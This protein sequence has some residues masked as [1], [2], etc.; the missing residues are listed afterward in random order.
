MPTYNN[1]NPIGNAQ[2]QAWL[3]NQNKPPVP[4]INRPAGSGGGN[5]PPVPT[6]SANVPNDQA[7]QWLQAQAAARAAAQA[8]AAANSRIAGNALWSGSVFNPGNVFGN[9][10]PRLPNANVPWLSQNPFDP[11]QNAANYQS[12][13]LMPPNALQNFYKNPAND[14]NYGAPQRPTYGR[15]VGMNIANALS[16]AGSSALFG[17]KQQ[18]QN[19]INNY[20][21]QYLK[22]NQ[23]NYAPDKLRGIFSPITPRNMLGAA[24]MVAQTDATFL[25]SGIQSRPP[26]PKKGGGPAYPRA[27][28]Q[29]NKKKPA[30]IYGGS[31]GYGGRSWGGGGW[32]GYGGGYG[33]GGGGGGNLVLWRIG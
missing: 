13:Y 1:Y 33:G 10:D 29:L 25:F 6:L 3:N 19:Q 23:G 12:P 18:T 5:R 9:R 15:N 21:G 17:L 31:Y 4:K 26:V 27:R 20:W 22:L 2:A 11:R 32:D 30:P 28:A 8:K 7:Q 14:P 24:G 16:Y